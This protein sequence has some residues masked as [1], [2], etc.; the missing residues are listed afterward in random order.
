MMS[1]DP[2][3][4][5]RQYSWLSYRQLGFSLMISHTYLPQVLYYIITTG[6]ICLCIPHHGWILL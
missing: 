5:V 1:R 3:G 4:A 2:K 6:T